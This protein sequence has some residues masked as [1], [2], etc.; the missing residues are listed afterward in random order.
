[1]HTSAYSLFDYPLQLRRQKD[2]IK[3]D[4]TDTMA[5]ASTFAS[6]GHRLLPVTIDYIAETD[7][8]RVW[9]SIPVSSKLSDGYRDIKYQTFA[10]AIDQAAWFLESTFGRS[11]DFETVAYIGKSDMRYHILSM[12]AAKTG[13]QVRP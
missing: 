10:N 13:Y 7:P 8:G 11:S 12:A 9:A 4:F 3:R 6:P 2:S 5:P 1:M